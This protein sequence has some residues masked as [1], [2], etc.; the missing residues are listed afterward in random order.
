[1][2]RHPVNVWH[3]GDGHSRIPQQPDAYSYLFIGDA[4]T[5]AE[6]EGPMLKPE[7]TYDDPGGGDDL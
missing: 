7:L 1:M 5:W 2:K 4:E 3:T 6:E